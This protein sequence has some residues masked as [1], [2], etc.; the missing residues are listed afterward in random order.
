M[1]DQGPKPW[2][3]P[4]PPGS[5]LLP[6]TRKLGLGFAAPSAP[7]LVT[8]LTFTHSSTTLTPKALPGE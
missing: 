7:W 8:A 1:L 3:A 5:Q 6:L 4:V 2:V